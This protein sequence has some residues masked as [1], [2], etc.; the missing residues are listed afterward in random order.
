MSSINVS[1]K[2]SCPDCGNESFDLDTEA[3]EA[4][5]YVGAVCTECSRPMTADDIERCQLEAVKNAAQGIIMD[6]FKRNKRIR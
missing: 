1:V 5:N 3:R 6:R 2:L 4:G